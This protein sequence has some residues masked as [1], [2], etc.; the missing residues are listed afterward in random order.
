[1]VRKELQQVHRCSNGGALELVDS[2]PLLVCPVPGMK[3]LL[4]FR[5][6]LANKNLALVDIWVLYG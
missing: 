5:V 2:M 6:S 1:M 4:S 3:L